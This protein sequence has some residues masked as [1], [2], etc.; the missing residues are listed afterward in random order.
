MTAETNEQTASD[1]AL[2]MSADTLENDIIEI[3]NMH[4]K[5]YGLHPQEAARTLASMIPEILEHLAWQPQS[6]QAA[7][8]SA[9]ETLMH[10]AS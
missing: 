6:V 9:K 5:V 3:I 8:S 10:L 2:A 4:I 1:V 7:I